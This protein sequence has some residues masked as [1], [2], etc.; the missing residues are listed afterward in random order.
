[1]TGFL[2]ELGKKAAER[3]LALLVVP[4]LLFL[5]LAWATWVMRRHGTW[6]DPGPVGTEVQHWEGKKSGPLFLAV[7]GVLIGA[8]G[9]ALL[10]QGT[11]TAVERLWFAQRLGPVG[12]WL[13]ARRLDSWQAKDGDYE[14]ALFARY[15]GGSVADPEVVLAAR[16][17]VCLVSPARPTWMADR[18]R[19]VGERVHLAY[20]LDVSSLWP[21]LWLTVPDAARTELVAART[22][23]A[24]DARIFAWGL[25][26]LV[27]AIWWWPAGFI[28]AVTCTVAWGRAR[29]ATDVLADLAE[30]AVDLYA[31]ALAGQLGIAAPDGLTAEVGLEITERLRKDG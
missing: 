11:G 3:W 4:G 26:Y 24:R 21:R 2:S 1:M 13:T 12:S 25:F 29:S 27:P 7:A 9:T 17:R 6:F 14:K 20:D 8:A 30:S 23:L 5:G 22:A 19:A 16:N 28:T 10:A 18:V 31:P 15:R